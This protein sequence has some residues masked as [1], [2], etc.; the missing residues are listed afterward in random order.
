MSHT[1]SAA[2]RLARAEHVLQRSLLSRANSQVISAL[3]LDPGGSVVAVDAGQRRRP[4]IGALVALLRV[5]GAGDGPQ[6]G[7]VNVVSKGLALRGGPLGGTRLGEVSGCFGSEVDET[8]DPGVLQGN[9]VVNG[10]VAGLAV[11]LAVVRAGPCTGGRVA[12]I[13]DL[14]AIAITAKDVLAAKALAWTTSPFTV[15]HT[16]H[17][18]FP[19]RPPSEGTGHDRSYRR[20]WAR[21]R[22]GHRAERWLPTRWGCQ[23]KDDY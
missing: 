10:D 8:H 6:L 5:G 21:R 1:Q 16:G 13:A 12:V 7:S 22:S 23:A 9:H 18:S 17:C 15:K 19:Q 3:D 11:R 4:L 20:R 2:H 14:N